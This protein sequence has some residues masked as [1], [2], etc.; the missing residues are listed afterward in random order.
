MNNPLTSRMESETLDKNR[1]IT[2]SGE[3]PSMTESVRNSPGYKSS[4]SYTTV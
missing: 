4:I 3:I 2:E 1:A